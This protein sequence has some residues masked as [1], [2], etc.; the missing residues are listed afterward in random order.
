MLTWERSQLQWVRHM[1][2]T[3]LKQSS[4]VGQV[5]VQVTVGAVLV[6]P[7]EAVK[8]QEV[9]AP[10][11]SD[12]LYGMFRAETA[13]PLPVTEAF[14]VLVKRCPSGQVQDTVHPVMAEDPA[15]TVTVPTKPLPHWL[16]TA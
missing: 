12:P 8:P 6:A 13:A 9:L 2:E 15:V 14:Q 1:A 4:V 3:F 11:A 5:A 16:P 10:A 7:R